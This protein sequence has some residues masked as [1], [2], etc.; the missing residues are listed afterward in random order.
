MACVLERQWVKRFGA[1]LFLILFIHPSA[2]AET[3]DDFSKG[4]SE[5]IALLNLRY[6]E[7]VSASNSIYVIE[8]V[9]PPNACIP[10]NTYKYRYI[11]QNGSVDRQL[12]SILFRL[13]ECADSIVDIS[14][15]LHLA[16]QKIDQVYGNGSSSN[17]QLLSNV[18]MALG[19]YISSL[20]KTADLIVEKTNRYLAVDR[21]VC[22]EEFQFDWN[23][24]EVN[25]LSSI[26]NNDPY[27]PRYIYYRTEISAEFIKTKY[28]LCPLHVNMNDVYISN[29]LVNKLRNYII[30]RKLNISTFRRNACLKLQFDSRY[31]EVCLSRPS[32]QSDYSISAVLT[33]VFQ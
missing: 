24:I 9:R 14:Y 23:N 25:I 13:L 6:S 11:S 21:S 28:L 1:V 3:I 31:N 19:D 12:T 22:N 2:Y 7:I 16:K 30:D 10:E 26:I 4:I 8:N 29:D 15:K 18:S 5:K 17:A 32:A 20:Q 33:E 27:T